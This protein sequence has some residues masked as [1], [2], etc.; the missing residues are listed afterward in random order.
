MRSST[1]ILIAS[2]LVGA[3]G[4]CDDSDSSG[5]GGGSA[6]ESGGVSGEPVTYWDCGGAG[7]FALFFTWLA[8]GCTLVEVS[9]PDQVPDAP[10]ILDPQ[11]IEG[12]SSNYMEEVEPNN[13]FDQA[14]PVYFDGHQSRRIV[15]IVNDT[16]DLRDMFVL[17]VDT[18]DLYGVYL[19]RGVADCLEFLSTNQ[20]Y[21]EIYDQ[22]RVLLETTKVT[23]SGIHKTRYNF[24]PG[25]LYYVAVVADRTFGVDFQYEMIITK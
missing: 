24:T 6:G 11:T 5:G 1:W 12:W 20:A 8:G 15:G 4:G 3:C 23:G 17:G 18:E 7:G 2:L 10:G 16:G 22:N 9:G 25:I 21:I 14:T 19:C 13:T